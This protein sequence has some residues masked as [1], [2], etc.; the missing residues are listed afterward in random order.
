MRG[1]FRVHS[2]LL[3]VFVMVVCH[4]SNEGGDNHKACIIGSFSAQSGLLAVF[5]HV[6]LVMMMTVIVLI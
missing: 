4:I 3:M 1:V 5:W 2:G 6:V